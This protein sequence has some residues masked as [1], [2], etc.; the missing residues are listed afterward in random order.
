MQDAVE[1][2][3]GCR[4]VQPAD[5]RLRLVEPFDPASWHLLG[6]Q[7]KVVHRQSKLA[8]QFL[9]RDALAFSEG[10]LANLKT[11][12][13]FCSDGLVIGGNRRNGMGHRVKQHKFKKANCRAHLI[14][15]DTVDQITGVLFGIDTGN[16]GHAN[17][18]D[19]TEQGV[20]LNDFV[21]FVIY[22]S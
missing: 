8:E 5:I 12:R 21:N 1:D 13:V 17:I 19:Q 3:H 2:S 22:I 10:G 16:E 4:T 14:G 20:N 15:W 11:P 6:R 18:L 9:H 7:R